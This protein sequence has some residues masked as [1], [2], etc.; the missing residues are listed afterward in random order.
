[1]NATVNRGYFSFSLLSMYADTLLMAVGYFMLVPLLG[2]HFIQELGWSA[3]LS[4]SVLAVS[5]VVQ[6]GMKLFLGMLAD[7]MGYR[8]AIMLGVATRV[9]GYY[10]Y[11]TVVHP[12]GFVLAAIVS[13]LGG[14]M[15]HPAS[16]A[17]YAR[18]SDARIKN[19]IYAI[20]ETLSNIGFI[21]GPVI[22]MFLLKTDFRLVCLSA[23][24]MFTLSFVTTWFLIPSLKGNGENGAP[25]R[26]LFLLAARNKRF[27]VFNLLM[28]GMWALW[29]QLY[30]VVPIRAQTVLSDPS[31]V[32]YLYMSGAA[33]MVLCQLPAIHWL[34]RCFKPAHILAMG[35][36]LL[37][38]ALF[39][40]GASSGF[41]SLMAAVIVFTAGQMICTPTMNT[42][43][44]RYAPEGCFATF[45]G[46]SGVWL[47]VGSLAGNSLSGFLFDW[48]DGGRYG[49]LPWTTLFVYALLLSAALLW[50][51]KTL[52]PKGRG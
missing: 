52:E 17:A 27:V 6:N 31:A 37:G 43:I 12:V 24:A 28:S 39:V 18:L 41:W 30:L 22:G 44:S 34:D 50:S 7:R 4:G 2:Y 36:A 48:A 8:R 3:A 13:G 35:V 29:G 45:F 11:A 47:A 15:F 46:F 32:S 25:F 40:M 10:L 16:Y 38:A 26:N 49:W 42:M 5:G 51:G 23:A 14:A 20:R 21:I 1:M 33:F 9:A 19:R